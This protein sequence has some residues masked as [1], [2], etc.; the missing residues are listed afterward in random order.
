MLFSIAFSAGLPGAQA[1]GP[2]ASAAVGP[3]ATTPN[4]TSVTLVGSLQSELG[5]AGD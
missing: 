4:P 3:Q 2:G 5:C 1:A